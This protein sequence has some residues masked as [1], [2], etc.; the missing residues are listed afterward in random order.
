M[1]CKAVD[2]V[3]TIKIAGAFATNVDREKALIGRKR[4]SILKSLWKS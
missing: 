1:R 3:D 4:T 2:K